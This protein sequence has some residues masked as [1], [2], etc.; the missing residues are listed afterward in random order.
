MAGQKSF[1]TGQS[2]VSGLWLTRAQRP[3]IGFHLFFSFEILLPVRTPEAR[4]SG[5][6]SFQ[7]K[8]PTKLLTPAI[9]L[10]KMFL[11]GL[12]RDR[13]SFRQIGHRL[14]G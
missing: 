12:G 13:A 4:I 7:G 11:L 1:Y 8:Q 10:G 5:A 2:S 6:L 9:S 3:E 14:A